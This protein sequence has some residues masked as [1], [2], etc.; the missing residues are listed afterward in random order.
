MYSLSIIIGFPKDESK[1]FNWLLNR[2]QSA[3]H[4]NNK[5]FSLPLYSRNLTIMWLAIELN[6]CTNVCD[7]SQILDLTLL[8]IV[9]YAH[10]GDSLIL[11]SWYLMAASKFVFKSLTHRWCLLI[12]VKDKSYRSDWVH[13]CAVNPSQHFTLVQT[14]QILRVLEFTITFDN[15]S[16][17]VK[18]A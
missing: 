15:F 11:F 13:D 7:Q 12:V 3:I 17:K 6:I 5:L 4:A 8:V 10:F 1:A 14:V 18:L 9:A 2:L 16:Y